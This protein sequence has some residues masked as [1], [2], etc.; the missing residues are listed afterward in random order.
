MKAN[1]IQNIADVSAST[2]R[3]AHGNNCIS[4]FFVKDFHF[5]QL[6]SRLWPSPCLFSGFP[7][8]RRV[9]CLS[10][11]FPYFISFFLLLANLLSW[12]FPRIL[13]RSFLSCNHQ[14]SFCV[15]FNVCPNFWFA[16]GWQT[17]V[18]RHLT[19]SIFSFGLCA[20]IWWRRENQIEFLWI[21]WKT[22]NFR[23]TDCW[24]PN[25]P[26]CGRFEL[27]SESVP[28]RPAQAG[29]KHTSTN[30][31]Q[32]EQRIQGTVIPLFIIST[33]LSLFYF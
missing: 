30:P 19:H 5:S 4:R 32:R 12:L 8:N 22:N 24:K 11:A 14:H 16:N 18:V 20:V 3:R 6:V 21:G 26:A 7:G 17:K 9:Q 33:S 2:E 10:I 27:R 29:R 15:S 28:A 31:R 1:V 25:E 13:E 23:Y